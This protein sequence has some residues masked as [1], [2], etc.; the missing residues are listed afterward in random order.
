MD[1]IKDL[2]KQVNEEYKDEENELQLTVKSLM[3]SGE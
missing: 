2:A 1:K 3:V